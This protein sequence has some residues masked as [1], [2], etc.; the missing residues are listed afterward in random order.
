MYTIVTLCVWNK[1]EIIRPHW[2]QHVKKVCPN[3]TIQV[4]EINREDNIDFSKYA[5]W[6]VVR[7]KKVIE[8]LSLTSLPVVHCDLDVILMKDIQE[9]VDLPYDLI[10]SREIGKDRTF[11][12]Q[13]TVV[14]Y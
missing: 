9:I 4:V 5:W 10:I 6:D 7:T 3:A 11:P 13:C 12:T 2:V 1:F 8:Y 14:L